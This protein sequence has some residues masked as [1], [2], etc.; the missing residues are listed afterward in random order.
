MNCVPYAAIKKCLKVKNYQIFWH[1]NK[2]PLII[3]YT[4]TDLHGFVLDAFGYS[5][6]LSRW[7]QYTN[8]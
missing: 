7:K 2:P 6:W 3:R 1:L 5:S 8:T 4:V